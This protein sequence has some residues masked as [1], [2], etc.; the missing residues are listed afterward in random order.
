[1]PRLEDI[2]RFRPTT[3]EA[4]LEAMQHGLEYFHR[5]SDFR[6]VFLRAYYITTKNVSRA[7]EQ[8]KDFD[9]PIFFEPDWI[10]AL[11][12]KFASLY[13][14]SLNTFDKRPQ[15]ERAWKVAHGMATDKRSSVVQDLLL[16]INAHI[17][18]DLPV[19]LY[20]NLLEHNDGPDIISLAKRKFDH[21]QVNNILIRSFNE[22]SNVIPREYG[23]SMKAA[24][25]ADLYIYE[26]LTRLGLRHYRERVWWDGIS[27][28]STKS[29]AQRQLVMHK[30]NWESATIA[31][32]IAG[33]NSAWIRA[34]NQVLRRFR[35][36]DYQSLAGKEAVA[37]VRGA[38][39]DTIARGSCTGTYRTAREDGSQQS[40]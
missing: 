3:I 2:A 27:L 17:N 19:A 29:E 24:R 10:R 6:A 14:A 34:T 15:E 35:R 39:F 32:T 20:Q 23:G 22:I 13:F 1:M 25:V 26:S 11:S 36:T 37:R 33:D 16:G 7:I 5:T 28:M 40:M 8:Q 30:L 12:G 9:N 18:Y 4:A 21:D 31:G 38:A